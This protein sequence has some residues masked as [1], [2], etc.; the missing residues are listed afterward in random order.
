MILEN[1]NE[2]KIKFFTEIVFIFFMYFFQEYVDYNRV[3][4]KYFKAET[5]L[6]NNV[7]KK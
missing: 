3:Q 5:T 4:Y 1:N 6:V 7:I 2:K